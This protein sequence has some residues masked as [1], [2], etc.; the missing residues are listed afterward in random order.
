MTIIKAESSS[1]HARLVFK[2]ARLYLPPEIENKM[3][4]DGKID[5]DYYYFGNAF[6]DEIWYIGQNVSEPSFV[7]EESETV[8]YVSLE[9]LAVGDIL[10][11][12]CT[13]PNAVYLIERINRDHPYRKLRIWNVGRGPFCF[14]SNLEL[15]SYFNR[16]ER[17]LEMGALKVETSTEWPY[18]VVDQLGLRAPQAEWVDTTREILFQRK[19]DLV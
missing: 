9:D 10:K 19:K 17:E 8:D 3:R 4:T 5:P 13:H 14:E 11:V 12:H 15:M 2:Q 6:R 1:V 16:K 18:F 7:E